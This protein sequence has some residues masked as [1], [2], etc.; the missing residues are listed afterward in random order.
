MDK[1]KASKVLLANA[2][3]YTDNLSCDICPFSKTNGAIDDAECDKF[4]KD[5]VIEAVKVLIV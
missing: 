3:C 4:N 1:E 2:C 5:M